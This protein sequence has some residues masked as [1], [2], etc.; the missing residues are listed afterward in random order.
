MT[1]ARTVQEDGFV[2][3]TEGELGPGVYFV[4]SDN[5]DKAKRFAHDEFHR[6]QGTERETTSNQPAMLECEVRLRRHLLVKGVDR[7]GSWR[8][9]GYD[10][11]FTE[12]TEISGS[13]EWCV[14]DPS[15]ITVLAV[16]DLVGTGCPWGKYCPYL[17]GN[18]K[19]SG[20]P[21][22]GACP[23]QPDGAAM[24]EGW[25]RQAD[26]ERPAGGVLRQKL[27]GPGH[28]RAAPLNEGIAAPA[29]LSLPGLQSS[30]VLS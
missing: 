26:L 27:P 28:L 29:I 1:A 5:I 2:V 11:A 17:G 10:A 16:H 15:R 3:S 18:G 6:S 22:G 30:R 8:N 14:A 13:T 4:D 24:Q 21:W 23:C 12:K 20:A 7:A 19:V 9:S 25:L